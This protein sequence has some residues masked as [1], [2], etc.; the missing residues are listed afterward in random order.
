MI[1]NLV[2]AYGIENTDY[3]T[4]YPDKGV[5][6]RGFYYSG[7]AM[8]KTDLC[9][10]GWHVPDVYQARAMVAALQ[11][12]PNYNGNQSFSLLGI[13]IWGLADNSFRAGWCSQDTWSG[14]DG[15]TW[16]GIKNGNFLIRADN[17]TDS[18]GGGNISY[19][20]RIVRCM[21]D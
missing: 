7:G 17:T 8:Q 13:E 11:E 5:G 1:D 2:Y 3:K 6:E 18:D 19:H 21:K 12:K 14:W 16:W 9:P 4:T 20:F 15:N 10:V